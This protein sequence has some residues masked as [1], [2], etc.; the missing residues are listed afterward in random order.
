MRNELLNETLFFTIG[1]ARS[2]L[3]RWVIDYNTSARTPRSATP[4]RQP[5]LPTSNS[6]PRSCATT[7]V[8]LWLPLD[9]RRG[10]RHYVAWENRSRMLGITSHANVS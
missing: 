9:E 8:G 10:S 2:T 1:Q 5:S 7:P 6:N 4:P 3:A